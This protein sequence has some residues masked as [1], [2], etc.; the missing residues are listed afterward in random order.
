M[1]TKSIRRSILAESFFPILLLVLLLLILVML[2]IRWLFL[3]LP[4]AAEARIAGVS[5]VLS[6]I[7]DSNL[8]IA[9][10]QGHQQHPVLMTPIVEARG[11]A[12][13]LNIAEVCAHGSTSRLGN[14]KNS[15]TLTCVQINVILYTHMDLCGFTLRPPSFN[16]K[17]E[18]K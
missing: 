7:I 9:L 4:V 1:A 3:L 2:A 15:V 16:E 12:S 14:S 11:V 6:L 18:S 13:N 8:R 10:R 17:S 5:S